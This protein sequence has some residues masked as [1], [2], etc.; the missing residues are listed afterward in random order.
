M[1]SLGPNVLRMQHAQVHRQNDQHFAD[2]ILKYIFL[3]ENICILVT[4]IC[5]WRSKWQLVS[6]GSGNDFV[7]DTSDR[8]QAIFETTLT[9]MHY[10]IWLQWCHMTSMS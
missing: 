1:V 4:E 2:N 3:N 9:N 10:A 8:Q 7:P 5:S 6:I